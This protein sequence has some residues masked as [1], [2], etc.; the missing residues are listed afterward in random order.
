MLIMG[1][2]AV[3][4]GLVWGWLAGLVG[5]PVRWSLRAVVALVLATG[6]FAWEVTVLAGLPRTLLF[7]AGAMMALAAGTFW[8]H[9]LRRR[10]GLMS[11]GG[12]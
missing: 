10:Y 11:E 8:R 12:S 5:T 4:A 2:G 3:G 6:A 1:F 7:L 9:Q